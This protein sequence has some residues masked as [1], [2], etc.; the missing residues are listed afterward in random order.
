MACSCA[1]NRVRILLA[2][3][4]LANLSESNREK[5]I[6]LIEGLKAELQQT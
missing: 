6:N 1:T 5:F 4:A 3:E 2:H